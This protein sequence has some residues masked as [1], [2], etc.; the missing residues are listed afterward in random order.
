MCVGGGGG[1]VEGGGRAG[2]QGKER[3]GFREIILMNDTM[4]Y[5]NSYKSV[6]RFSG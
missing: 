5:P 3:S 4:Y 1:G 6:S 2:V